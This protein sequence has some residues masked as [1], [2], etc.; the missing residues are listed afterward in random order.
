MLANPHL[1]E[2]SKA[3]IADLLTNAAKDELKAMSADGADG[4]A[5]SADGAASVSGAASLSGAASSASASVG[6]SPFT[7]P[8]KSTASPGSL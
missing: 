8:E 3:V 1:P 4:A 6:A 7:T 5:G 2:E